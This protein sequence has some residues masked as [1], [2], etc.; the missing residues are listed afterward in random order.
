MSASVIASTWSWVTK[1]NVAPRRRW[2]RLSATRVSVQAE[3]QIRERLV[4]QEHGRI[5]DDR[6]AERDALPLAAGELHRVPLEQ[7]LEPG[8]FPVSATL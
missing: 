8:L 3:R 6:A 4:E 2:I 1:T 5:A 7:R